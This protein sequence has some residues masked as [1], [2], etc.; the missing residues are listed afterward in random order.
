VAN[1]AILLE[2]ATTADAFVLTLYFQQVLGRSP[3]ATG[4]C[5][6]PLAIVAAV[7]APWT[8]G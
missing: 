4:R 6:L 1:A 7:A 3:L 5:F 2:S 8:A